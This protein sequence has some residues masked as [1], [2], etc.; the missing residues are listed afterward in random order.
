ML[1]DTSGFFCLFDTSDTQHQD[2]VT[3]FWAA[4]HGLNPILR[5][6]VERQLSL[7]QVNWSSSP[8]IPLAANSR[9]WNEDA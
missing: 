3:L 4:S 1:V 5:T 8:R 9:G 2:A 7:V 6:S